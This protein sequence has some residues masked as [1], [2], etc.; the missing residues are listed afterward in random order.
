MA[1]SSLAIF[2]SLSSEVSFTSQINYSHLDPCLWPLS[3]AA[4]PK[5]RFGLEHS[6]P[7]PT[8][9]LPK[10]SRSSLLTPQCVTRATG[11]PLQVFN[12]EL[13]GLLFLSSP[14][15]P[16]LVSLP[17]EEIGTGSSHRGRHLDTS[18]TPTTTAME[19]FKARKR[20]R[21]SGAP[22]HPAPE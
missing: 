17:G 15:L 13:W 2:L 20:T 14:L 1:H 9:P 8:N 5:G 4:Q 19:E 22:F 3:G 6:H 12:I 10:V 21:R 18:T 16:G 7:A 11:G